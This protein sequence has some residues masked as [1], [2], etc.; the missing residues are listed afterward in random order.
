MSDITCRRR[1]WYGEL[2]DDFNQGMCLASTCSR[3]VGLKNKQTENHCSTDPED[4]E[5]M[6]PPAL[7]EKNRRLLSGFDLMKD[8]KM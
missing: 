5:C 1:V 7:A 8:Q 3:T 6:R 2:A 4:H